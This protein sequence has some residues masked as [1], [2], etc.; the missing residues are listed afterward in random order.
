MVVSLPQRRALGMG[1]PMPS[2]ERSAWVQATVK[3]FLNGCRA[4]V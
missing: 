1:A 3:L 4:P 2:S